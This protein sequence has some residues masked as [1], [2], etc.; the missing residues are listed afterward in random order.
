MI[1]FLILVVKLK[2]GNSDT[3][4]II[5]VFKK[6]LKACYFEEEG[7]FEILLFFV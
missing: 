5:K 1:N 6:N 3:T 7:K 2:A 4:K